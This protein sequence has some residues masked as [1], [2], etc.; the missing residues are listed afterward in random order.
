V[1][2]FETFY[3]APELLTKH[4]AVLMIGG[5]LIGAA[6]AALAPNSRGAWMISVGGA[7]FAAWMALAVAGEVARREVVD[8]AIG[9]FL[10]PLGIAFR[11]DGLG[12]TMALLVSF[13]GVLAALYSGH[14]LDAEVRTEKHPLV[15]AALLLCIAGMLGVVATGDAFNAFVFLEIASV[16][17]Y[18]LVAVGGRND[19]RA[20]PA[21][22]NYLIMGTIGATFYVVGVGFLF[23]A[24][25][26]LNMADI[27][28]RVA[29]LTDNRGV[30]VGFS[31]IVVGLGLKAAMF[32]LHGWLP[33][34]YAYG[35][36]LV[37]VFLAAVATKVGIYLLIRF[38]F[39]VFDPVDGFVQTFTA[40]VLAPLAAVA[41]ITCSIQAAFGTEIRR[42]L[43]FSSVA[44]VGLIL[45]GMSMGSAAGVAAGLLMLLAHS[46]MKAP[47]FMALGGAV[48]GL[49]ART[50]ADFAGAGRDA[51]WTMAAFAIAAASLVGVPFTAGFLAK[52]RLMEAGLQGGHVWVVVAIAVT[53]LLT[54]TYVA[55]IIEA[56][57]VRPAPASGERAKEAPFGVL[58]PLWILA[59]TSVWFGID[60]SLPEGL[61]SAGAAALVGAL[62]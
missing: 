55:R 29:T 32:P 16:S 42:M 46:L 22:F 31:F 5:P 13:M 3:A 45:I 56:L 14:A 8:Y 23:G 20:L 27:A 21:A 4:A 19:R 41:A 34:A 25:G 37:T 26:T 50:L 35:P 39:G 49:R 30:Q 36:S 2:A 40:F 17:G 10:P 33:G 9:G 52:W 28:G 57:F 54:L 38:A 7:V 43:A 51:P 61:A 15:Q 18:A 24:T 47:M 62:P 6:A 53:S 58:V 11:I 1:I 60:A 59:L 12:A 44:Q 48:V